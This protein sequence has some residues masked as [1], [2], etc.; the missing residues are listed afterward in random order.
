LIGRLAWP[1]SASGPLPHDSVLLADA[2]FVLEPDLDR[3][4]RSYTSK[5]C[6]QRGGEVFLKAATVSPS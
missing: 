3:L 4:A 6:R 1:R 5:M 2:G